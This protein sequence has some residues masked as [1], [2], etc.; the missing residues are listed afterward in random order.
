[1]FKL[2]EPLEIGLLA[3]ASRHP[4]S[5]VEINQDLLDRSDLWEGLCTVE[6]VLAHLQVHAPQLLQAPARL[7]IDEGQAIRAIYL[8][9][10]SQ[11]VPAFYLY[12]SRSSER[13]YRHEL[14]E[15]VIT[16]ERGDADLEPSQRRQSDLKKKEM[17]SMESLAFS[18]P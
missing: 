5:L 7:L 9:D 6:Q 12:S 4:S 17:N 14:H 15:P 16:L 18:F 3:V 1:M 11:A 10:R 8:L 13:P 2:D